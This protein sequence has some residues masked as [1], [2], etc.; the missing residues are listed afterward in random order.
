MSTQ[1]VTIGEKVVQYTHISV[2]SPATPFGF[3]NWIVSLWVWNHVPYPRGICLMVSRIS[4]NMSV[5]VLGICMGIAFLV[6]KYK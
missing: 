2:A 6:K 1:F 3:L 5:D 4:Y